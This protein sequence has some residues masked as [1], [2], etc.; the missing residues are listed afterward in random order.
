MSLLSQRGLFRWTRP[1]GVLGVGFPATVRGLSSNNVDNNGQG[2]GPIQYVYIHPLSQIVLE[3][4]QK[5]YS[6]WLVRRKLHINSLTVS[7]DGTFELTSPATVKI[8]AAA[9]MPPK[10][11]Q[12]LPLAQDERRRIWTSFD[13]ENK[14][15]WLSVSYGPKLQGRYMLQD[16]LSTG[17]TNQRRTGAS[18]PERIGHAVGEM[19]NAI[20][21][22][23]RKQGIHSNR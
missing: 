8:T 5:N 15:H 13:N 18:L 20:D 9:M 17:W 12:Q 6:D 1:A 22:S 2:Q 19:V 11:D 7:P 14:K 4:L 23:E 16:N 3:C 10:D 21:E